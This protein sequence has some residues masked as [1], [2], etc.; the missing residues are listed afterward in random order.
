MEA[1]R[2]PLAIKLLFFLVSLAL[3]LGALE[4]GLRLAGSL[5]YPEHDDGSQWPR[6]EPAPP[7]TRTV[8]CLGDSFTW[9]GWMPRGQTFPGQLQAYL[10]TR[11]PTHAPRVVNRGQCEAN[12][13]QVL[14]RVTGDLATYHPDVVLLLVGSANR[15]NPWG[16][17][18]WRTQGLQPGW[19]DRLSQLRVVKLLR[20]T[21]LSFQ[22]LRASWAGGMVDVLAQDRVNRTRSRM[23]RYQAGLL[24]P[25]E[26]VAPPALPDTPGVRECQAGDH[27]GALAA[28]RGLATREPARAVPGLCALARCLSESQAGGALRELA[29]VTRGMEPM[30]EELQDCNAYYVSHLADTLRKSGRDFGE[31]LELHLLGLELDPYENYHLYQIAKMFDLQSRVDAPRVQ[32]TFARIAEANPVLR[33][34]KPFRE[35]WDTWRDR[36][37]WQDNVRQWLNDDLEAIAAAVEKSGAR[38]IVQNY[39]VDY[40]AANTALEEL[41]RRHGAAF[42]NHRAVF[43]GR[44]DPRAL[45]A[46][47]DHCTAAGHALMVENVAPTLTRTLDDLEHK[48]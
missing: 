27:A 44:P 47:D 33:E 31:A 13:R 16:Y 7:G 36:A 1:R 9:A 12:S 4:L 17:E 30:P 32:A 18:A 20:I 21:W 48:P 37:R 3:C 11:S 23:F 8:L 25:Q 19:A 42:V 2:T 15:F 24:K 5:A 6:E 41:A 26:G 35:H 43:A 22:A 10:A 34:F 29:A 40:P 45:L 38:L 28:A 14:E 46:D 39:P